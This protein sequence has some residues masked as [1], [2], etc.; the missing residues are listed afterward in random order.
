MSRLSSWHEFTHRNR[1]GESS[2]RRF[3]HRFSDSGLHTTLMVAVI[4]LVA[5]ALVKAISV[6]V[7]VW[8]LDTVV[9]QG[10][11]KR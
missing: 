6:G 8:Q 1:E 9:V 2:P 3:I 10:Q 7:A 5:L 11:A 4:A